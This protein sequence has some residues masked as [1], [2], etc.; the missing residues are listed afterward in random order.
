[1]DK[2]FPGSFFSPSN[3]DVYST[4]L[5]RTSTAIRSEYIPRRHCQNGWLGK[6]DGLSAAATVIATIQ[7]SAEVVRLCRA[8]YQATKEARQDI[9]RLQDE[10]LS[11][12][13]ILSNIVDM[14]DTEIPNSNAI[15]SILL[16]ADGPLQ[17]YRKILLEVLNKLE[18][19]E[20]KR[21]AK[22]AGLSSLKWPFRKNELEYALMSIGRIKQ[23]LMLALTADSA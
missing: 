7:T 4:F 12:N 18:P 22:Q 16:L 20:N 17:D 11:L 2:M 23:T 14:I 8:Y 5:L 10:V 15:S 9:L 21:W 19:G 13:A 3:F 1:M 6:M